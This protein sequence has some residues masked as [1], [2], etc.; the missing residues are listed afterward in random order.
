[1]F[2]PIALV[3]L[4]YI[5]LNYGLFILDIIRWGS[6]SKKA[7]KLPKISVIIP[8]RDDES[9]IEETLKRLG[10]AYPK[11]KLDIIVVDYSNDNT[12]KIAKRYARVIE[13]KKPGKAYAMNLG[14]MKARN[15]IIYFL[16]SDTLVE[17]G[18]IK[19]LIS[20]GDVAAGISLP[21]N[22]GSLAVSIGRLENAFYNSLEIGVEGLLKTAIVGG[23][24]LMVRKAILKKIKGFSNA[25]TEDINFSL[26]LYHMGKKIS[27]VPAY[28][29]S[30]VP[31]KV[32]HYWKQQERWF[33]GASDELRK[34]AGRLSFFE[35]VVLMPYL[36][37]RAMTPSVSIVLLVLF[38][39]FR[40]YI[41]LSGAVLGIIIVF[42]SCFRFLEKYDIVL[43]PLIFI[44]YSTIDLLLLIN[45]LIRLNRKRVWYKTP[46]ASYGPSKPHLGQT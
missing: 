1:M 27:L 32:Q 4:F 6:P 44:L 26:K 41:L 28:C 45:T 2:L 9:V 17:K 39:I 8:T 31:E 10:K 7:S 5:H 23:K 37:I 15:E 3:M 11:N 42:A 24:N 29:Y 19:M 36:L 14:I 30:Q 25:L 35:F 34:T 38:F 13:A 40:D 18:T 43:F 33:L 16:D 46:K 21:S 20:A 22:K 12:K